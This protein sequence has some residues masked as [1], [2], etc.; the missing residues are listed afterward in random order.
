MA[1]PE[2]IA[3]LWQDIVSTLGKDERIERNILGFLALAE[4]K[5]VL[6]DTLYVEVPNDLTR[7]MVDQRMRPAIVEALTTVP[8]NEGAN[9]FAIFINPDIS[10]S[11]AASEPIDLGSY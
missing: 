2:A 8:N 10:P 11:I 4:P 1:A 5:G 3:T 6:G 9:N 7:Q